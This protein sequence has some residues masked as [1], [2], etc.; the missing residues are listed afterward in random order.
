[1][2]ICVLFDNFGPYHLARLSALS[3]R[4]HVLPMEISGRSLEY[5]WGHTERHPLERTTLL[6]E[7]EP[8]SVSPALIQ[9]R[10][11]E[12]LDGLRPDVIAV[13]GWFEL[14]SLAAIRWAR[15]ARVPVIMMSDSTRHDERRYLHKEFIKRRIVGMC[16]GAMVGGIFH[17]A[18]MRELGMASSRIVDGYDVVDNDHFARGARV[19]RDDADSKRKEFQLP[20][21]YF[22]AS[23]RWLPRK[24]LLRLIAAW[25]LY[26][27]R[28]QVADPWPLV[29]L[30]YGEGEP[31]LRAEIARRGLGQWVTLAGFQPYDRLP[32]YYGLAGAFIHPALSEPWG[33][34]VNEAMAAG[35]VPIVSSTAG[36]APDLV[37]D[38]QTGFQFQPTDI[39]QLCAIMTRV[40][41]DHDLR[42]RIARQA[43]DRIRGWSPTRFATNLVSVAE[44]A[45][46]SENKST[47]LL[48]RA[49]LEALLLRAS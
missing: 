44:T 31:E 8:G 22:L 34:V 32:V 25:D 30:G 21:E 18:Y 13:P 40:S 35:L 47:P 33:L 6:R 11:L 3:E 42:R 28:E 19:A 37:T 46:H 4:C 41:T 1:M 24:N 9:A 45:L 10:L 36:C 2:K 29:I 39:A 5:R 16:S 48:A 27:G 14:A 23:S 26:R 7:E 38:G 43:E 17:A 49:C 20:G 15:A 12:C